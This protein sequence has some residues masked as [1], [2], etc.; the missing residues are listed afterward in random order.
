MIDKNNILNF[1][2]YVILVGIFYLVIKKFTTIKVK[3]YEILMLIVN[4]S[5]GIY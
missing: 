5:S 1:V 3:E 4:I 2:K